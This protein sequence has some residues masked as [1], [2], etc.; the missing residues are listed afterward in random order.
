MEFEGKTLEA[1]F[2]GKSGYD[3]T[4]MTGRCG[5]LTSRFL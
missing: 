3:V 4:V 5:G 1:S 2:N